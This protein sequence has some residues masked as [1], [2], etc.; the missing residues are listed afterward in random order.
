MISVK[1]AKPRLVIECTAEFKKQVDELAKEKGFASYKNYIIHLINK[2]K[3]P[4]K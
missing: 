4:N 2:D 1:K 3:E